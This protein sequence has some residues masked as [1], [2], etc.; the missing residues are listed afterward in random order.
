MF[1]FIEGKVADRKLRLFAV[2]C[3]RRVW[4]LLGEDSRRAVEVAERYADELA[5]RNELQMVREQ[6][7]AT[8]T[9][10]P[11]DIIHGHHYR[12]D[13]GGHTA[14]DDAFWAARNAM[15]QSADLAA[16]RTLLDTG[17]DFTA[18]EFGNTLS[19]EMVHRRRLLHDILGPLPF[20]SI[21]TDSSWQTTNVIAMARMI[22]EER[23]FLDMPVL[24]DALEE[25]GCINID[26]VNHCRQQGQHVRGC[27]VVDLILTKE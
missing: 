13:L 8:G 11:V 14:D 1:D 23:Q 10:Y 27:W 7:R 25:A 2:A 16:W 3:C 6:F 12:P 18:T 9:D 21:S 24:G 17:R 26:L 19:G 15:R 5:S 4:S 22:Y 20:R